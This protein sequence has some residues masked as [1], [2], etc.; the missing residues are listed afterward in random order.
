MALRLLLERFILFARN[1]SD[2][3]YNWRRGMKPGLAVKIY[4]APFVALGW[5]IGS[6]RKLARLTW[7]AIVEGYDAGMKL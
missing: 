4:S 3:G 6:L 7:A 5:L 1:Y 2:L